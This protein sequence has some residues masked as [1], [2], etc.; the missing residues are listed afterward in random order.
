[1]KHY[2]G[3]G[4]ARRVGEAH[5]RITTASREAWSGSPT[6]Q[7]VGELAADGG[8]AVAGA[9]GGA[10]TLVGGV[11]DRLKAVGMALPGV[12]ALRS[13]AD[14]RPQ[15]AYEHTIRRAQAVKDRADPEF[16]PTNR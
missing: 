8:S 3:Q 4:I 14:Q 11:V 1:V 12:A 15:R 9:V 2:S 6:L 13:Y 5:E 10:D 16:L 7:S